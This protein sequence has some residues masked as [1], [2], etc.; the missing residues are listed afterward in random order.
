MSNTLNVYDILNAGKVILTKAAVQSRSR[1]CTHNE[2]SARYHPAP[3]PHREEL[4]RASATSAT[5]SRCAVDANK[6][7]IKLALESIFAEDG[8]KVEKVNTVRTLG[9]IKRQGKFAGPHAGNQEGLCHSEEGLQAD[10][11]L[12][13]HGPVKQGGQRTMA[14][15]NL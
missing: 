6:T 8:V 4:T 2:G 10:R 13:G 15:Q 12:R 9:K 1:R 3:G 14:I 7:E 5:S 11:V